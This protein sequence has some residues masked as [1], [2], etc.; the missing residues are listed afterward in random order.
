M[1]KV[2]KSELVKKIK[3]WSTAYYS[4]EPIISDEKFDRA[5]ELLRKYD[6]KH[7]ILKT[8]GWGGKVPISN[9]L[10][11]I[12]HKY[13]IK[14]IN[15]RFKQ[16]DSMEAK[17]VTD[18]T[19][20]YCVKLGEIVATPKLDGGDAVAYYDEH[21]HLEAC[22]SAGS[23][24][25]IGLDITQNLL[26]GKTIP[27][28][29]DPSIRAVRGQVMLSWKDFDKISP[30]GGHPRN[31]AVGL[32]LSKTTPSSIL[33]KLR[34]I[35]FDII[36]FEGKPEDSRTK[37]SDLKIL[38]E[39]GFQVVP[40]LVYGLFKEFLKEIGLK[41]PMDKS[42]KSLLRNYDFPVDGYVLSSR[43]IWSATGFYENIAWKFRDETKI[44]TVREIEY[45]VS[46][47]GRIVPVVKIEPIFLSGAK[48]SRITGN[49]VT[50][51]GEKGIGKG[52]VV[53]I[54]RSNLVIPKIIKVLTPAPSPIVINYCPE[55]GSKLLPQDK[56]L[57]CLNLS[58]PAKR[59]TEIM[60]YFETEQ[61]DGIGREAFN[62]LCEVCEIESLEKMKD[63][64]DNLETK[65]S[66]K[67]QNSFGPVFSQKIHETLANLADHEW[68]IED[69]LRISNIPKVGSTVE[70]NF[71]DMKLSDFVNNVMKKT[72]PAKWQM[73]FPTAPAFGSFRL[74]LD[75][76]AKTIK[77]ILKKK[78]IKKISPKKFK[79]P[80]KSQIEPYSYK[81]LIKIA[82]TGA[83]S[84]T[85]KEILREFSRNEYYDITEA[86]IHRADVLITE[87]AS[88][89][90]KYQAA[91]KK[92][93]PI[94]TE[95]F[96]RE[97]YSKPPRGEYP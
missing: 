82:I 12:P 49:N 4:G 56:D 58:C 97:R 48:I 73:Y 83:L 33:E 78:D 75:K 24:E 74:N 31:K 36:E 66:S 17:D 39:N 22:L 93:I 45:Q 85:R 37:D 19:K 35:A 94:M 89:S 79:A 57:I 55:C 44:A 15:K 65:Y 91:S 25:R 86:P 29:V 69:I 5:I 88:S 30:E 23:D 6:S 26:P 53:E 95:K 80:N 50:W 38:K 41:S 84:K 28:K 47:T 21:G 9:H 63:V 90:S 62:T 11:K 10:E 59:T 71:S 64:I 18:R 20:R 32:S 54:I 60:R 76:I 1:V 34:F 96:F 3:K 92:G 70:A 51:I 42:A 61:V 68:T 14:T 13:P 2:K 46:R 43:T 27:L 77:I 52:A 8:T 81:P 87:K 16:P 40:Y 7:P 67:I 72:I